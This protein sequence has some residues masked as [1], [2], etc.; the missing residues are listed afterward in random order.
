MNNQYQFYKRLSRER[1]I[2]GPAAEW[3]AEDGTVE[4]TRRGDHFHLNAYEALELLD[5]LRKHQLT[6]TDRRDSYYDCHE[7][8]G[9]HR[10]GE[11]CPQVHQG[12]E[13]A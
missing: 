3:N 9:T 12:H 1:S 8:G 2:L 13:G 7:C 10:K 5:W 4:L 6:L 11:Q